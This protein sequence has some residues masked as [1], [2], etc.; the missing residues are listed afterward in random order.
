MTQHSLAKREWLELLETECAERG[1][2]VTRDEFDFL[3][4]NDVIGKVRATCDQSP[5]FKMGVTEELEFIEEGNAEEYSQMYLV[6]VDIHDT[7]TFDASVDDFYPIRQSI[8]Q[9]NRFITK[10]KSDGRYLLTIDPQKLPMKK[11]K[12]DWSR[13]FSSDSDDNSEVWDGGTGS[14][15]SNSKVAELQEIASTIE[16]NQ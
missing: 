15:P 7:V 1:V 8:L 2:G 5:P 16:D 11:W 13:L 9:N 14:P 12:N 10:K 3:L 6:L 4:E